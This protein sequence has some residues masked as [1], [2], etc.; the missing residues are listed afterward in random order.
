MKDGGG[1][2]FK[3]PVNSGIEFGV[4]YDPN[5]KRAEAVVSYT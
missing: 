4:L 5:E 1:G 2:E 3:I